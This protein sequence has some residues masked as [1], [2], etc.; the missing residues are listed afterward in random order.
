MKIYHLQLLLMLFFKSLQGKGGI[1]M[2]TLKENP[3]IFYIGRAKGSLRCQ[4]LLIPFFYVP[5]ARCALRAARCAQK[6]NWIN[7]YNPIFFSTKKIGLNKKVNDNFI[8]INNNKPSY[9]SKLEASK[10]L[11]IS[12]KTI[13][14]YLGA[15]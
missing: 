12:N 4:L 9:A 14:K 11:K 3:E 5:A 7:Q 15:C 8:L 6:K 10:D 2:F 13:S 1:Y